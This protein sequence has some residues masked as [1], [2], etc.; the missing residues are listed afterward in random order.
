MN[1]NHW[2]DLPQE[3]P[4]DPPGVIEWARVH[5]GCVLIDGGHC[6]MATQPGHGWGECDC[7]QALWD[8]MSEPDKHA[9]RN[10]LH[11]TTELL[12]ATAKEPG[13]K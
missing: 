1:L 12:D 13:L 2:S 6:I 4:S 5:G 7:W 11:E 10:H 8:S 9:V 3:G